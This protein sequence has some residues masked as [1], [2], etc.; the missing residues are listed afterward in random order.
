RICYADRWQ[1]A[2]DECAKCPHLL[3]PG[4]GQEESQTAGFWPPE[5][6]SIHL[7]IGTTKGSIQQ[8]GQSQTLLEFFGI[9]LAGSVAVVRNNPLNREHSLQKEP[10][11][12]RAA[13][14]IDIAGSCW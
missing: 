8:P 2:G 11:R 4:N 1:G 7:R 12:A 6:V 5:F 10:K 9:G 3:C 14:A 13:A